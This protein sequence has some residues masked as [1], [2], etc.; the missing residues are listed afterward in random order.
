MNDKNKENHNDNTEMF[1]DKE[2]QEAQIEKQL[3]IIE[4][5]EIQTH[6]N[7]ISF[8]EIVVLRMK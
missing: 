4:E 3:I 5:K 2:F 1:K 8:L 6:N 7:S